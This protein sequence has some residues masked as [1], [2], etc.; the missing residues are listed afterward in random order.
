[1]RREAIFDRHY[2]EFILGLGLGTRLPHAHITS[3]DCDASPRRYKTLVHIIKKRRTKSKTRLLIQM[4][5]DR[6]RN[7]MIIE[8]RKR[9]RTLKKV[10]DKYYPFLEA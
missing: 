10:Y 1:M 5:K 7:K 3:V 9:K 6:H 4:I 2:L 8:K